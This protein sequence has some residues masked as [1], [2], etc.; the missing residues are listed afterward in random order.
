MNAQRFFEDVEVGAVVPPLVNTPTAVTLFRFSAVTW[1]AHRIHYDREYAQTEGHP[2]VLVQ[3]H[4]HGAWLT[5]MLT[6]WMGP[7]GRLLSIEWKNRRRAMPSDVLTCTGAVTGKLREG[8]TGKLHLDITE[9]NQN[10]E[11][12]ASG[13]AQVALPLR[14]GAS[15]P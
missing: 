6:D 5:R 14:E 3:A 15:V 11:V 4:M 1:N 2:G 7:R 12:C 13:K 10:G 8:G 9:T